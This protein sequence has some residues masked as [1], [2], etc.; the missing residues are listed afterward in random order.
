[1][2]ERIFV[3]ANEAVGWGA[4]SA[5]CMCFFGY[6]I[7]PQNEITEWFARE[8]PKRG[9]IF[10]QAQ[11]ETAAIN[12]LYGAASVGV[13]AI[14]STSG[15][16]WGLMQETM[17]NGANAEV[18]FVVVL[19]QRGGPGAGTTQH[20]QMD[21][22]S[23]TKGGGQ[24]GYKTPVLAPA[25]VQETHDLVQYAFYLADKHRTP[26]I[27]LTDAIVGQM[28]EP[29]EVKKLDF[30]PLPPKDWAAIGSKYHKDGKRVGISCAQGWSG[31]P[32]YFTY[33][34]FLEHL[35]KKYPFIEETEQKYET[36]QTDDAKLILVAYGYT[37]RVSLEAAM[38]A[39]R[40]GLKVGVIRPITLWPFPS[41][42]IKE[43]TAQKA[44]FLVVEDS[45]GQMVEDVKCVVQG[46][47]DVHFLGMLARHQPGAGG[48]IFP[49]RVLQ[50][51]KKLL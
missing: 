3:Q 43:K 48:M 33:Q 17:S 44:R 18:P 25:S 37:A 28:A 38:M 21:Y 51:V 12:M 31:Q 13:R 8:L 32:P 14:T 49:D 22:N 50:E 9:K 40:E 34:S 30:G 11:C 2:A 39:R 26:V 15:P 10:V 46:K 27:V 23:T 47:T 20:A 6:P 7:T 42:I 35:N 16:G 5:D 24:G 19:V 4:V 36:W 29:L 41:N 45:L 1:M